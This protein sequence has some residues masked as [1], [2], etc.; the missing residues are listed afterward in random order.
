MIHDY[1]LDVQ[2][3]TFLHQYS[4]ILPSSCLYTFIYLPNMITHIIAVYVL[5][6]HAVSFGFLYAV[7]LM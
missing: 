1:V 3:F 2:P 7:F 5:S 4:F 6:Y